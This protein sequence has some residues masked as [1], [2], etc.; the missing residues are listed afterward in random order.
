MSI[1]FVT[2]DEHFFLKG[3]AINE[4]Y[5]YDSVHLTIKGSNKLAESLG[6]TPNASLR[7]SF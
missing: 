6:L 1:S 3:G 2:N 7:Y 4:G 5:F